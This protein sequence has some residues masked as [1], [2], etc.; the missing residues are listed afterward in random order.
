MAA[1]ELEVC[2]SKPLR[3]DNHEKLWILKNFLTFENLPEIY[4][5]PYP[6]W[7]VLLNVCYIILTGYAAGADSQLNLL[8]KLKFSWAP[9]TNSK[10]FFI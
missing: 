9:L 6:W 1:Q 10:M 7:L 5:T 4:Q 3:V 8:Y 2:L